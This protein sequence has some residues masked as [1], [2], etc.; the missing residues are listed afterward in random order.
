MSP[1]A[2]ARQ[3]RQVEAD[4]IAAVITA[5]WVGL[6]GAFRGIPASIYYGGTLF[7]F[8]RNTDNT[9]GMC[10]VAGNGTSGT[11]TSLGGALAASPGVAASPNG[12]IGVA[13]LMTN[14][15]IQINY[16]NPFQG[17]ATGWSNFA[18]GTP[19]GVTFVGSPVLA[20]NVN[21]RIEAFTLDSNGNMWHTYQTTISTPILW[22]SWSSLGAPPAGL[23]PSALE[24]QVF[25]LTGAGQLQAV[26][27]GNDSNLYQSTQYG[28]GGSDGWTQFTGISVAGAGNPQF[29]NG[30]TAGYC[31]S[32]TA[33][34]YAGYNANSGSQGNPLTYYAANYP[35]SPSWTAVTLTGGSPQF[36]IATAPP[37]MINLN[38]TPQL[39]WL[40]LN[41][42]GQVMTVSQSQ[43]STN[44]WNIS[45]EN[46]G[47][48]S[49]TF[50]GL[51]SGVVNSSN[52]ALFQLC[53][54]ASLS[55]INMTS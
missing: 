49:G 13:G 35:A 18:G 38:G 7:A 31:S 34:V 39:A 44:F 32:T 12:T 42:V 6:G 2:A 4:E 47:S 25:L 3:L 45:I 41:T 10:Q 52:V 28:G 37:V 16:V 1:A 8:T 48:A 20:V 15:Q 26:A 43:V 51:M 27:L 53:S 36:P 22:S 9:L 46:V 5:D 24:F 54:D 40:S 55:Y 50:T 29:V 21:G 11:W 33:A 14:G 23:N 17:I 19:A 30:P